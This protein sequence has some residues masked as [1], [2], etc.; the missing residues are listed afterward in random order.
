MDPALAPIVN[1]TEHAA[2]DFLDSGTTPG[3]AVSL[4]RDGRHAWSG[5]LGLADP[6]SGT[7]MT[8]DRLFRIASIT[9]TFVAATVLKL[10]D[11]GRLA[12]HD[13][14]VRH[15]PDL[16]AIEDPF[17]GSDR[18]TV[19]QVLLHTA[20]LQRDVPTEPGADPGLHQ[21][22]LV[23]AL[24]R[25]RFVQP[26]GSR[27]H[28]S[29]LG[30]ELLGL[31]VARLAGVPTADAVTAAILGPGGL[32]ET[33]YHPGPDL[34][35]RAAP[36]ML[37]GVA[38]RTWE[39]AR[40]HDSDTHLGDG[41]LWSTVGDLARWIEIQCRTAGRDHCGGVPCVLEDRTLVELGRPQVLVDPAGWR[42]AQGLGFASFRVDDDVWQGHTGS[43]DGFRAIL[44]FR[45]ADGLGVASL[46][47]G[48][49]R[50]NAVAHAAARAL[51]AAHR[52][53][54]TEGDATAAQTATPDGMPTTAVASNT[55]P[56]PTG[57]WVHRG[58]GLALEARLDGTDLLVWR[59]GAGV[60]LRM[61]SSGASDTWVVPDTDEAAGEL[62]RWLPASDRHP[63]ILQDGAWSLVRAP[64]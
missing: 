59:G 61:A 37:P 17:G 31:L 4:V 55:P 2:A 20:G 33:A 8:G 51:L 26:P 29:N 19:A 53:R 60:S 21:G 16:A 36:G 3:I 40:D 5:G 12:L 38:G 25:A 58:A 28:Y 7:P 24:P 23:V 18:V 43:I 54:A 49:D 22:D 50:P 13:P 27:W 32:A 6:L 44:L 48:P 34:A 57:R 52:T 35:R 63:E 14:L 11:A 62:V 41:G 39:Q 30:Y 46:T 15:L 45:A 56:G 64:D 1:T 9:K 42:S 10:R 47:N